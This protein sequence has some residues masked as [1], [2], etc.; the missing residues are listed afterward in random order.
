[1]ARTHVNLADGLS[2]GRASAGT[3]TVPAAH[4]ETGTSE[5]LAGALFLNTDTDDNRLRREPPTP[6]RDRALYAAAGAQRGARPGVV[7]VCTK[8]I[9]VQN[10]NSVRS[11]GIAGRR[12][13]LEIVI[14]GTPID[15]LLDTGSEVTFIPGY[16]A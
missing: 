12:V 6:G 8:T 2:S 13:Y 10:S 11:R 1:M 14:E 16:P 7:C 3:I 4:P 5:Q 15:C 9:P